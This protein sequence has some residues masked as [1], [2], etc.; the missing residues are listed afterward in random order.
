MFAAVVALALVKGLVWSTVI[1]AWYGPDEASHY[2]YVQGLV[3][4][5]TLPRGYDANA[6]MYFAPEIVCSES[7]LGIGAFG[8]FS[9]EPPF[10]APWPHCTASSP[11]DRH[12]IVATNPAG[13][14][15]PVYY[16]AATPFYLAAQSL[17]VEARLAAVRLWSVLLGTLAAAFAY[18]AARW[19][20]P[21]SLPLATAAAVLFVLQPMNS[22]QTATVNNDAL[23]IA[24]AAAFW[25]WFFRALRKGIRTRDGFVFG[26]LI[27]LAYL[28]KPQGVFLAAALPGLYV[29]ALN[30]LSVRAE[31]LRVAR[32][33]IAALVP[34]AG[35]YGI[36]RFFLALGGNGSL[37]PP[38]VPGIH[39]VQQYLADY[40]AGNFARPYWL[41][42]TSFWGYFGWF[43]ADLPNY[44]YVLI[45]L[46]V[47]AGVVG[48]AWLFMT[49]RPSRPLVL[50]SALAVLVPGVLTQLLELYLFRS[51]GALA[52]QGRSF[53]MLLVPLIVVIMLG[54]Q[55][56][57][58]TRAASAVGGA[59]VL[60]ATALNVTS[61]FVMV[62]TFYG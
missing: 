27:G 53:L 51:N 43:Q 44:V 3:E 8:P 18:L 25:W 7:N 62:D 12:A 16:G 60:A 33:S 21:R 9:A 41:Y 37:F 6:G 32:L 56:F 10:G 38:S 52:L 19:A 58:P 48:A 24:A 30:R 46:A 14:Y 47:L 22:Q 4:D 5:H 11:S 49:S 20:F 55:R 36:A 54:W 17:S 35:C 29:L 26:G 15:S 59:I 42:I 50:A 45:A 23:L 34:I 28:A 39:G 13:T 2:A 61:L 40:S 1:P 31:L 57:F